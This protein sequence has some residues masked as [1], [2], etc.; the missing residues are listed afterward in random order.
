MTNEQLIAQAQAWGFHSHEGEDGK[1]QI[2]SSKKENKMWYLAWNG[3]YW[4]MFSQGCAVLNFCPEDAVQF[5][6]Q[7][8]QN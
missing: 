7:R 5:L 2:F 1:L 8:R 3:Q 6:S 4:V